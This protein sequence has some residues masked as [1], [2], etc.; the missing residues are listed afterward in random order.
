MEMEFAPPINDYFTWKSKDRTVREGFYEN[1]AYKVTDPQ[2]QQSLWIRFTV[3][4]SANG[5]RRASE[6]WVIYAQKNSELNHGETEKVLLK[7]GYDIRE[8]SVSHPENSFYSENIEQDVSNEGGHLNIGE[9]GFSTTKLWGKLRSKGKTAEWDFEIKPRTE[10]AFNYVPPVTQ[11]T[12]L[13]RSS[14]FNPGM[15]FIFNGTSTI[16][17][18]KIEWKDCPGTLVRSSGCHYPKSWAFAHCNSF[19]SDDGEPESAVFSGLTSDFFFAKPIPLPRMNSF[20]FFYK[21]KHYS[22]NSVWDSVRARSTP[23]LAEWSF[24]VD[25]DQMSFRGE[26][27]TEMK[28]FCGYAFEDTNGTLLYSSHSNLTDMKLHVYQNDKLEKT[29]TAKNSATFEM[30]S[31]KKSPYI[32]LSV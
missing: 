30:V 17:G 5:F 11:K 18:R 29:L 23:S 13:I 7:K 26:L 10:M 3:L 22:F 12:S 32:P 20:Y 24:R 25:R 14:F 9:N 31:R 1:W 15:D 19:L 28:D 6:C 16:K 2:S 4:S 21:G 27:T 8:F